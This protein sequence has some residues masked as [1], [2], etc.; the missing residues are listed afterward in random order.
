MKYSSQ[1][2]MDSGVL[3]N[4]NRIWTSSKQRH[5]SKVWPFRSSKSRSWHKVCLS[6]CLLYLKTSISQC[7][8][9]M[10]RV[11]Y[12]ISDFEWFLL[13]H[14]KVRCSSCKTE[15]LSRI[16]VTGRFRNRTQWRHKLRLMAKGALKTTKMLCWL[17]FLMI[18]MG[19]AFSGLLNHKRWLSS[20]SQ[21]CRE[22]CLKS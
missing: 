7:W 16:M 6:S 8:I 17:R 14:F 15:A 9:V 3:R 11:C 5:L 21:M 2:C 22:R 13:S 1:I 12:W 18:Q 10:C 20:F 19:M 4:G